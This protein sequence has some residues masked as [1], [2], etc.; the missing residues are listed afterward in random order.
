MTHETW[1]KDGILRL[2]RRQAAA[3]GAGNDALV[4]VL[5]AAFAEDLFAGMHLN[6]SHYDVWVFSIAAHASPPMSS[7]IILRL[8]EDN[9]INMRLYCPQASETTSSVW[10]LAWTGPSD[11]ASDN[12]AVLLGGLRQ[13]ESQADPRSLFSVVGGLRV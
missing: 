11:E 3:L 2:V 12:L 13:L 6:T 8:G 4:C 9:Q 7:R 10:E 5:E 1:S